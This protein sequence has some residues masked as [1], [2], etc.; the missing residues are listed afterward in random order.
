MEV[1]PASRAE[2]PGIRSLLQACGLPADDVDGEGSQ[3]FLLARRGGAMV[4][5]IGLEVH[6]E[7]GLL[8]SFAVLPAE[9]RHGLGAV[10]HDHAVGLARS[11]GVQD[12]YLLTTTVRERALR[13]GFVDVAREAVPAAIREGAQFRS[14]CPASASCLV[15]HV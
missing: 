3:R 14:L 11:L 8:R 5:C 13:A 7:A 1:V 4:G 2:I 10:L 6:G 15:F 12:L 9:R